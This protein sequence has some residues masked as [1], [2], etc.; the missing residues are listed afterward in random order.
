MLADLGEPSMEVPERLTGIVRTAGPRPACRMAGTKAGIHLGWLRL[1][2]GDDDGQSA[3]GTSY[4]GTV[5]SRSLSLS[6]NRPWPVDQLSA[7]AA[8]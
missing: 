5:G 8:R 6:F 4:G 7:R 1:V 2:D 3:K